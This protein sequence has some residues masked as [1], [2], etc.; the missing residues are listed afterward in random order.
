MAMFVLMAHSGWRW[1]V[2][3]LLVVTLIKMLVGWLGKRQWSYTTDSGLLVAT[4]VALYIQVVLGI[5][6]WILLQYWTN[7]RFTA[8]HAIIAFISVGGVEFGSARAKKAE[9]S[10]QKYKMASIG[11]IITVVLL[12]VALR[13]VGGFFV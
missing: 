10:E 11:L 3:V 13:I 7:M 8:E 4:R 1:I 2:L 12:W 5:V 6:L 9:S